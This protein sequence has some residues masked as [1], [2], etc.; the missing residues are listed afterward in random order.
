MTITVELG[1]SGEPHVPEI[2][3]KLEHDGCFIQSTR[4]GNTYE[5]HPLFRR[6]L[7]NLARKTWTD[8]QW[9][10]HHLMAAQHYATKGLMDSA[11][12]SY[13]KAGAFE[14]ALELLNRQES[15]FRD[16]RHHK[17]LQR[18]LSGFPSSWPQ[19]SPWLSYW[20]GISQRDDHPE[21]AIE[22][23]ERAYQMFSDHADQTGTAHACVAAIDVLTLDLSRLEQLPLWLQRLHD[24][25]QSMTCT[26]QELDAEI[27]LSL[28]QGYLFHNP[29]VAEFSVWGDELNRL[30][31][32]HNLPP[33]L[34]C[35][36]CHVLLLNEYWRGH[37]AQAQLWLERLQLMAA[38]ASKL[39]ELGILY[40]SL[41]ATLSWH[42]HLDMQA[43]LE[44]IEKA[45]DCIKR[46]G[47]YWP[48]AALY[49]NLVSAHLSQGHLVEARHAFETF[50]TFIRPDNPQD[51]FLFHHLST[52]IA[53]LGKDLE[54]AEAHAEETLQ[55]GLDCGILFHRGIACLDA[56]RVAL[57]CNRLESAAEHLA[58]AETVA[59]SMNSDLL[60]YECCLLRTCLHCHRNEMPQFRQSLLQTLRTGRKHGIRTFLLWEPDCMDKLYLEALKMDL[61]TD[62]ARYIIHTHRLMPPKESTY[63][64][65]WPW[66][67]RIRTLG[68]FSIELQ[69]EMLTKGLGSK[70]VSLLKALIICGSHD[71][72]TTLLTEMLWPDAEGDAAHES[73]KVTL[74]RLRALLQLPETLILKQNRLTLNHGLC[75]TDV[76]AFTDAVRQS[77][78]SDGK[79]R[80]ILLEK[81][82]DLYQG[83]FLDQEV[84][85]PVRNIRKQLLSQYQRLT[86]ELGA[87]YEQD[88][89]VRAITLYEK[90]L[91]VQNN[92][93]AVFRRLIDCYLTYGR[94]DPAL[95]TFKR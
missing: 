30:I 56:T 78:N 86:L 5:L 2:L 4:K 64:E 68:H 35:Q 91:S 70:P 83:P 22:H 74:R 62:Y 84:T 69:G 1:L 12:N 61:E 7:T 28:F 54:G 57:A 51:L 32:D 42:H 33:H 19:T 87:W 10:E 47:L 41:A 65:N 48:K 53:L 85:L 59:R 43:T 31:H 36:V 37:F 45:L 6:F 75:W 14:Q 13:M 15:F 46:N 77:R 20:Q 67:I 39:P 23:L 52:L 21:N 29:G 11:L 94:I 93:E 17:Q 73:F 8:A 25:Q 40:H 55:L 24:A 44:H 34:W 60:D 95:A 90:S 38:E 79:K 76:G 71:V 66:P 92:M 89:P 50:R 49:S 63:A 9:R 18:H 81:A 88:K 80:I 82:F 16:C 27:V 72:D 26:Q 58:H 3:Q